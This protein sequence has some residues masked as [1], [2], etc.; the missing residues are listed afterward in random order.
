[1]N[2]VIRF[3]K[4]QSTGMLWAFDKDLIKYW[5]I[6]IPPQ[7]YTACGHTTDEYNIEKKEGHVTCPE[8]L[9]VINFCK[10]IK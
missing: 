6:I 7:D 1:M 8:C 10:Q 2:E 9:R 5:H 4:K 3:K